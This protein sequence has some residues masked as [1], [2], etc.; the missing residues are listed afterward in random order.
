[1]GVGVRSSVSVGYMPSGV[2]GVNVRSMAAGV[3]ANVSTEMQIVR[4]DMEIV[5]GA[6]RGCDEQE[7]AGEEHTEEEDQ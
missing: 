6:E 4:A 2:A 3:G 1:M 5:S 7:A